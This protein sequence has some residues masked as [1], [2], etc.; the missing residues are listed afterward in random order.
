M[1]VGRT[2]GAVSPPPG[3]VSTDALV[4][5]WHADDLSAGYQHPSI[6]LQVCRQFQPA[7]FDALCRRFYPGFPD[8]VHKDS[9]ELMRVGWTAWLAEKARED[10]EAAMRD[11]ENAS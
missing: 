8:W 11:T 2:P 10:A 4:S 3:P 9:I 6:A 1:R 7:S 5:L